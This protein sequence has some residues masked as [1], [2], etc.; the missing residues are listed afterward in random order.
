MAISLVIVKKKT[1]AMTESELIDFLIKF[2]SW[3]LH[4]YYK[5]LEMMHFIY[6]FL[7]IISDS[8]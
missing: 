5:M 4:S 7:S 6:E 2:M 1:H 3:N 8:I